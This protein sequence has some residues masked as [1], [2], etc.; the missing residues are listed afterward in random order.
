MKRVVILASLVVVSLTFA[1]Q[2]QPT[3]PDVAAALGVNDQSAAPAP[4]PRQTPAPSFSQASSVPPVFWEQ[5]RT[6]SQAACQAERG[7]DSFAQVTAQSRWE[8]VCVD[9]FVVPPG[10]TWTISQVRLTAITS[11]LSVNDAPGFAF[12]FPRFRIRVYTNQ[13]SNEP[14]SVVSDQ[15]ASVTSETPL[16][17]GGP[18][19]AE[20]L[21]DLPTPLS[22]GAGTYWLG[23]VPLCAELEVAPERLYLFGWWAGT[24]TSYPPGEGVHWFCSGSACGPHFGWSSE[25]RSSAEHA[26]FTLLR[27]PDT[28]GDGVA[29]AVDNCPDDANADQTDT[30]GDGIGDAC[31]PTPTGDADEDGI[32]DAEDNCP[33]VANPDQLDTDGDGIGDACDPTPNGDT[34]GDGV[35]ELADNCPSL[36]NPDQADMDGDGIGDVCDDHVAPLAVN[37]LATPNPVAVNQ[38]VTVG[39]LIDDTGAGGSVIV[40]AEYTLNGVPAPL[41]ADD[42]LLNEVSEDVEASFNA[43]FAA[44]IYDLCVRGTDDP[45]NAGDPECIMLVVYDPSGGFVTGGGW[46]NSPAGAYKPDASLTGKAS[47]GFVSKYKKGATVPTG[48]TEFQFKAGDLNFHSSSYDWLVVTGSDYARFKGSGTING[49]GDY[50]FMLWA[51]DDSPDTFRIRIWT[52]DQAGVETDVYDNGFDQA[53]GGGSIVIHTKK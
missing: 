5:S 30:D 19:A 36:P 26:S 51:G 23:V 20:Y 44:D 45:G 11:A 8:I 41:N 52:E 22:L 46:I 17:G 7:S 1:C 28:D 9:D 38:L 25:W 18:G 6:G 42:G 40:D 27:A 43:P 39:A 35:D 33:N 37:V 34:D 15:C 50:R 31:D 3:S 32:D 49:M 16:P 10:E 4:P 13:I 21:A 53:I 29:D 14:A 47:F 12:S 2:D 24:S 48:S